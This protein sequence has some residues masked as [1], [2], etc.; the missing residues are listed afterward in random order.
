MEE[1]GRLAVS[2]CWRWPHQRSAGG[3]VCACACVSQ[4]QETEVWW[5]ESLMR[6][7]WAVTGQWKMLIWRSLCWTVQAG[8]ACCEMQN[9]EKVDMFPVVSLNVELTLILHAAL[10]FSPHFPWCYH[11]NYDKVC[12]QRCWL[13]ARGFVLGL[14][15]FA[16]WRIALCMCV[17]HC[18]HCPEHH[19]LFGCVFCVYNHSIREVSVQ[20][21]FYTGEL[22]QASEERWSVSQA[23]TNPTAWSATYRELNTSEMAIFLNV[24]LQ[25]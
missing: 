25:G 16:E 3:T 24:P 11:V 1:A 20:H 15:W 17:Q 14:K 19:I 23:P 9:R 12:G 13:G 7:V 6:C 10:L 5:P 8:I 22:L 2:L 4:P 21:L 18:L